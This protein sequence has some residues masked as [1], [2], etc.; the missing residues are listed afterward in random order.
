MPRRGYQTRCNAIFLSQSV[1]IA[2]QEEYRSEG[3][4]WN[5]VGFTDNMACV[6]LIERPTTGI[7]DLLNEQSVLNN[8]TD[9][10][11]LQ[12]MYPL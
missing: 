7:M 9:S 11:W 5:D 6:N 8:G 4:Q 3:I 1:F 2:E 10:H 12:T